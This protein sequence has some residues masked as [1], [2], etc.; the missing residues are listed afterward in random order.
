MLGVDAAADA[1]FDIYSKLRSGKTVAV[2]GFAALSVGG[3]SSLYR[4]NLITGEAASMGT[5]PVPVTDI[6]VPLSR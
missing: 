6:A 5:F 3:S 2:T 1:G 4:I